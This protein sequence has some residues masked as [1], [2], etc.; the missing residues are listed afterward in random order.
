MSQE[1]DTRQVLGPRGKPTIVIL[2]NRNSIKPTPN[3]L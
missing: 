3:D 1:L 2:L